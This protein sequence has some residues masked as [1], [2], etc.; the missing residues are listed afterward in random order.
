MRIEPKL[1]V[2]GAALG[3]ASRS[4][5]LCALMDGRAYTGKELAAAAGV[6]PQTASGHL[7]H[8]TDL[9]LI[10][11]ERSGRCVYYALA[12]E[13]VA[14]MLEQVA[15]FTPLDH[16]DR[17]SRCRGVE[18]GLFVAR[19]CYR[20]F[21]GAL[22]VVMGVRLLSCGDVTR[23]ST[24]LVVT[25]QTDGILER[26]GICDA[27]GLR[28]CLDWTERKT[29]FG[30]PLGNAIMARCFAQGWVARRDG[31]RILDISETGWRGLRDVWGISPGDLEPGRP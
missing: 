9:A 22:A 21:G 17:A 30:G 12:G 19:S 25:P 11:G 24:G 14:D 4:R 2:I 15:T 1:D 5:I 18:P 27:L 23:R 20:H 26:I 6:S 3:D 10:T 13:A 7:R 16:L 8:L 28:S 31:S 29:H